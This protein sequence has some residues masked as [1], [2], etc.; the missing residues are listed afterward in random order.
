MICVTRLDYDG[1]GQI[2]KLVAFITSITFLTE[3]KHI[4]GK[5]EKAQVVSKY[6]SVYTTHTTSGPK[7]K[8]CMTDKI[9]HTRIPLV[10]QENLSRVI[11]PFTVAVT[12]T[13]EPDNMFMLMGS[14]S[15]FIALEAGLALKS[16]YPCFITQCSI[17]YT[18]L[19][20]K[21]SDLVE[22]LLGVRSQMIVWKTM[23]KA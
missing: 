1:I 7:S 12:I 20:F 5:D 13:Q 17:L 15:S 6:L 3:N 10:H 4:Y 18:L 11:L 2:L 14:R 9:D 19:P 21:R 22:A 8:E 16:Q 23:E